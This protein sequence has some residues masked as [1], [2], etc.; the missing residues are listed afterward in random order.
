MELPMKPCEDC[1]GGD[2]GLS[3]RIG[4]GRFKTPTA[5]MVDRPRVAPWN[6]SAN[7]GWRQVQGKGAVCFPFT[8][9]PHGW[10]RLW[11]ETAPGGS[12]T[13]GRRSGGE[14]ISAAATSD[15]FGAALVLI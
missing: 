3:A 14:L 8:R 2:R 12:S 4:R 1:G 6:R 10:D 15:P 11:I 9:V 13:A 7:P 5:A